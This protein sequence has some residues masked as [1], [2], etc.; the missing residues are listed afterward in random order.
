MPSITDTHTRIESLGT[1]LPS[2]VV[3]TDE[4]IAQLDTDNP[5]PL[6]A[7][8][9]VRERRVYDDSDAGYEDSFT[10][11][12]HAI[13]DCLSRSRYTPSEI[14]VVISASITRTRGRGHYSM[15]PSFAAV[16]AEE[17]G[18]EHAVAFDI[19]NACA[20]MVTSI[21]LLD[22]MIR[23]GIAR[24]GIVVSGEQITPIAA[25]A[26]REI[27]EK[28]DPQFAS[29]SVG[30]A[31]A[32][33]LLDRAVDDADRIEYVDLMTSSSYAEFCIGGPSR[34]SQGLAMYTDNKSMHTEQRYLQGIV[35]YLDYLRERGS[36]IEAEQL[37]FIIHHQFSTRALDYINAL[38]ERESGLP[39]PESLT[40]L[41]KYGNTASTSHFVALHD[42][43]KRGTIT[44]GS[45]VLIVPSASG[46][47]Y[48][49]MSVHISALGS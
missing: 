29:L 3:S 47:V 38:L 11:A 22:R 28:Y 17:I 41:E 31:G 30:D 21:M 43:L 4:L 1:Y 49:H 5:P 27:S 23:A 39:A 44:P 19:G 9:G 2:K 24:T 33:V 48:G 14:D 20:G 35:W 13:D 34:T 26:V 7:L 10:L 15:E 46:M 18:A 32:C 25:T 37:D 42:H 40:V 12:R 6:E 45:T 36:R 8:T 16:L